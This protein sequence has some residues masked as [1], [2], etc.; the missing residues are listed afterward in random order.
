MATAFLLEITVAGI[1][2][3]LPLLSTGVISTSAPVPIIAPL[4]KVNVAS[5]PP[6]SGASGTS[7][8]TRSAAA[9]VTI[10]NTGLHIGPPRPTNSDAKPT[11]KPG[12]GT[13]GLPTGL[14]DTAN[15]APP[16]LASPKKPLRLSDPSQALLVYK[17]E[18]VY[19]HIAKVTGIWG[20]VK[21]HAIIAKDGTI[22]SLSLISGH[23]ILAAAAR[24]AVAQW[25][26]RPYL[27]NGEAVEVETFIT[28]NFRKAGQ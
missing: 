9:I 16:S 11:A 21:L 13:P 27:L 20:V 28:V 14:A 25:R 19:P 3:A 12:W 17:V 1:L 10:N 4:L 23:P 24:D 5:Q 7:V 22:Q 15:V 6:N 26:Y 2:V 8:G 18:P